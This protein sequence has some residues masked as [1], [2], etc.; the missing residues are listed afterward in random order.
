[1]ALFEVPTRAR[2]DNDAAV[3]KKVKSSKAKAPTKI[4]G[5]IAG[6][7]AQITTEVELKLGK[8]R[9]LYV[10]IRDEK[11]LTDYISACIENAYISID[12]ETTGLNPLQ[13]KLVGICIYTRG[14]KGAYI[15][16]NHIDYIT[17]EKVKNQ[18]DVDF[19]RK[20]FERLVEAKPDVDM[21]NAKFDIRVLRHGLGLKDIYCTWD[22]SLASRLLN[23]NEGRGNRGLKAL[24]S[25]YCANGEEEVSF[26][27]LFKK[28]TADLIP[29]DVFSLY[30]CHDSMDTTELC[31]Y[32]RPFLTPTNQECID[33]ELQD[34][35]WVFHNIEMPCVK[36]VCDMEDTGVL[37][38]M[39]YQQELSEKYHR[40]LDESKKK[41]V[42]ESSKYSNKIAEYRKKNP[43][44][45]IDDPINFSSNQQLAILFYDILKI[46]PPDKENP[47]GTG[48]AILKAMHNPLADAILE[49][50]TIDKLIG[51]Y[52]DKLP[53]CLDKDDKRVHGE[54]NQ[55]GADTGRFS[56]E[57]P[58]LQ[59]IPSH[60][61]DIR[62]MFVA[63]S[64]EQ[65]VTTNIQ[66]FVVDRW[67]EIECE[68]GWKS[69]NLISI[70]DKLINEDGKLLIVKNVCIAQDKTIIDFT[71]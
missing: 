61:K 25:K 56:S 40:L 48:K 2:R 58:N 15:P 29:I 41:L 33:R 19:V 67:C 8:Y 21:F 57:N 18:L 49:Y 69:A 38:D 22:G 12:T 64:G 17:G 27:K 60:N 37:L 4:S 26:G 39:D 55:Y 45:K 47:R 36:V 71:Q 11:T 16:L 14:Q 70:G 51:T 3:A 6:I 52:I 28:I 30:A 43:N 20:E 32:Q 54:F 63:T 44:K 5:G 53:D 10:T 34:V 62:K 59:N 7:I 13:D 9:H 1:M 24:H 68:Q 65:I 66:Q 50:R 35:A 46:E 31:D 42:T 23:E